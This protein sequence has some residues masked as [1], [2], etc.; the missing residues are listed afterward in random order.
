MAVEDELD[1]EPVTASSIIRQRIPIQQLFNFTTPYWADLYAEHPLRSFNKE[2][3]LYKLLD[4]DG[5][6]ELDADIDVDDTTGDILL[7]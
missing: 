5:K 6:G 3:E 4:M 1:Q 2:L 7:G